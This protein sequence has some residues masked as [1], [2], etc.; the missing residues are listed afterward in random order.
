MGQ[1][2]EQATG[3]QVVAVV[4]AAGRSSRMG[5]SKQI[6]RVDGMPMVERAV[7]VALA[8]AVEAVIVVTGAYAPEVTVVLAPLLESA[9]TRLRLIHNAAWATG[10]AS[11]VRAA[12]QALSASCGAALFLPTDQPFLPVALLQ[13]LITAWRAGALLAAPAVDGQPRGAP[14][15]FARSLWDELLALEGDVGARPL[16]Q[17]HRAELVTVPAQAAWLRDIDTPADLPSDQ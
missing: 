8:S 2:V 4:L 6:E 3:E 17:R 9:G 15:I 14:A 16:L 1:K 11:S 13:E 7:Q 5:R 10:Q 12:V